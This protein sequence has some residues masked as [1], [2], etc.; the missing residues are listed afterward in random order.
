MSETLATTVPSVTLGFVK[1]VVRDQPAMAA[2]YER[3]LGLQVAQTIDNDNMTELVLRKPGATQGPM[4]ILYRHKDGREVTVGN[5]HGPV[6][7]YVRDVQAAYDHALAHG[8]RPQTPPTETG[9]MTYA[10]LFDPEGHELE[11]LSLRA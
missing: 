3:A 9:A 4:L 5:G 1:L 2:F 6:G 7:F 10:L 11:F 8:A